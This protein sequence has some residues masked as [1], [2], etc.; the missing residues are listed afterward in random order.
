MT[1]DARQSLFGLAGIIAVLIAIFAVVYWGLPA[2]LAQLKGKISG[3]MVLGLFTV[4][5]SV[6]GVLVT[7]WQ[8]KKREIAEVHRRKKKEIYQEFMNEVLVRMFT[9]VRKESIEA[10]DEE[11]FQE[12][13]QEFLTKFTGQM[14]VWG[15]PDV[16]KA[17][18]EW[19]R[20]AQ[21]GEEVLRQTDKVLRAIREDLDNSNVGLQEYDLLKL[22]AGNPQEWEKVLRKQAQ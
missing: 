13:L 12:D 3:G 7:Q 17:F 19:Q 16:V 22:I 4:V 21:E 11:T 14:I 10:L 2:L 18:L 1:S 5:G 15:S 6:V 9:T 20:A 8:I